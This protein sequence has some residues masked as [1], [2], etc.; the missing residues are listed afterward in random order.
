MTNMGLQVGR[1]CRHRRDSHWIQRDARFNMAHMP[2]KLD[3]ASIDSV[4]AELA[5]LAAPGLLS[6]SVRNEHGESRQSTTVNAG[7][8]CWRVKAKK[9]GSSGIVAQFTAYPFFKIPVPEAIEE[10]AELT[11]SRQIAFFTAAFTTRLT[12]GDLIVLG[13]E[14]YYGDQS[15]LGGLLLENPRGRLF[16]PKE[17]QGTPEVKPTLTILVFRCLGIR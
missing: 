10:L 5:G 8:F 12:A 1:Q 14:R 15:T 3:R 7:V 17:P 9:K 13:P 2:K 6:D 16:Y 4:M 11:R